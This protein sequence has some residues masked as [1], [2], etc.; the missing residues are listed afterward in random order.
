M[1]ANTSH[2]VLQLYRLQFAGN[3]AEFICLYV[4][5]LC[6]VNWGRGQGESLMLCIEEMASR[7]SWPI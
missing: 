1:Y 3:F 4:G 5:Y 7:M 6:P 2:G